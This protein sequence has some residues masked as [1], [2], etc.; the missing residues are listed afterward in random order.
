MVADEFE[1]SSSS[2]DGNMNV[3]QRRCGAWRIE[4]WRILIVVIIRYTDG[5]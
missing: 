5:E 1:L 3:S 2:D 4:K